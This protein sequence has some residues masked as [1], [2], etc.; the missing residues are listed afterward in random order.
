MVSYFS[1]GT[2]WAAKAGPTASTR[3]TPAARRSP[4]RPDTVQV[5]D[6]TARSKKCIDAGKPAI[7]I[8]Q[9]QARTDATAAVVSGKDDAML[10]DSPV[11][12]YAVEADQRPARAARRASTT[13]RRTATWCTKDQ[14]EFGR[15]ARRGAQGADRRRHLREDPRQVGRA[16]PARSPTRR[17]TREAMTEPM[18]TRARPRTGHGP[19]RSRRCPSGTPA[20]GSPIAVIAVLTAMFVHML[21][22]NDAFHWSFMSDNMFTPAG[23]AKACAAPCC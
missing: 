22:T 2:Q 1:A 16:R 11:G 6:V 17:S 21:V 20:A 5:D 14:A 15:G 18:D 8:D 10:A 12:A 23:A 3:T 19:S 9:F 13:P 4:C 7:T